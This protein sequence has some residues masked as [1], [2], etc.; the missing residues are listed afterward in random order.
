MKTGDSQRKKKTTKKAVLENHF[1]TTTNDADGD[2]NS[3][4][5]SESGN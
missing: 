2:G 1:K 4:T 5:N 3:S